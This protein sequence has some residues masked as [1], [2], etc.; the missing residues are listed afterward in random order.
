MT[1]NNRLLGVFLFSVAG[2]LVWMVFDF[3]MG[4]DLFSAPNES[5][6]GTISALVSSGIIAYWIS[7]SILKS[8]FRENPKIRGFA[9]GVIITILSYLLGSFLFI[10]TMNLNTEVI[11]FV[12]I[13]LLTLF[14][15]IMSCIYMSPGILFGGFTG[16]LLYHLTKDEHLI[17]EE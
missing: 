12:D 14:S 15:F 2:S 10:I 6:V 3:T 7:P 8:S 11:L 5:L 1:K 16:L 17:E 9:F 13:L 4:F